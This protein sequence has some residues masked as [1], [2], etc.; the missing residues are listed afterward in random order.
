M[1]NFWTAHISATGAPP[2]WVFGLIG[3][4]FVVD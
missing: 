4:A 2:W 3:I 1:N